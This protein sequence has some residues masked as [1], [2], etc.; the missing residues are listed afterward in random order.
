MIAFGMGMQTEGTEPP[1]ATIE[2]ASA[3]EQIQRQRLVDDVRGRLQ[4]AVSLNRQGR[5]ESALDVL[6]LARA[7]VHEASVDES[8]RNALGRQIQLMHLATIRA[9]ERATAERAAELRREASANQAARREAGRSKDQ[10]TLSAM[11]TQFDALMTQGNANVR[12]SDG[13]GDLDAATA[14]FSD[15]RNLA[16]QGRAA[17]PQEPAPVVGKFHA[18]TQGFLGQELAFEQL[19]E[20]RFLKTMQEVTRANVPYP[21]SQTI[22]FPPAKNWLPDSERRIKRY[23]KSDLL[24][25]DAK[26]MKILEKLDEPVSMA[27]DQETALED[28]LKYIKSATSS[29]SDNGIPIYVDPVGLQEADRTM[30]SPVRLDLE[31]VPLKTTLRLLLKQLGLTYTVKDGL[32]TIT[33]EDSH[34]QPSELR[35]YPVADLAIIPMSLTGTGMGGMGMGGMNGGAPMGS[36]GGSMGGNLGMPR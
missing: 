34:D 23:G 24:E 20:F 11:M 25:R 3:L 1:G 21:D 36:M 33:S 16:M 28:V 8:T 2:N 22:T 13:S 4:E 27:F 18:E 14:P 12:A 10:E 17:L 6:R 31:G 19:K 7:V 5:I 35:V 9:E 15:A 29:P 26:T 32:L 30:T